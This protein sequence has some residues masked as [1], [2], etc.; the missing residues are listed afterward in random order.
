MKAILSV[1]VQPRASRSEII[2]IQEGILKLRVQSPPVQGAAN[3]A[4]IK[5]L[6]KSLGIGKSMIRVKSGHGA[7]LKRLEIEG[8]DIREIYRR[9]Q[10]EA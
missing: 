6:S 7:R 4:V 10:I 5:L 8:M 3:E 2:G 1:K 9:L